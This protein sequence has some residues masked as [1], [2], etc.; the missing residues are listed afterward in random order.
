M[1]RYTGAD[2]RICRREGAKLFLKGERCLSNKCAFDKRPTVPGQHGMGRKKVTEYGLQLREKQKLKRTYGVLE[3]QFYAYFEEA[4]RRKGITGEI[5]LSLLETRL[6]NVVYRMGIASSRDEARQLV[7]HGHIDVNGS[8]VN[9][10]SYQVKKGDAITV[11]ETKVK[12]AFFT[13][14]KGAK[15]TTPKWVEFDAHKLAGKV[16]EMPAREDLDL[17]IKENLIVELYSK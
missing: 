4:S 6:D 14:L 17:T 11:K 9:I 10:P 1:A 8:N 3:K 12:N 5:M 15:I 16:L 13:E 7:S 2:C